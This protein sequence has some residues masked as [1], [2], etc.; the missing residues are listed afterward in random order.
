MPVLSD[1]EIYQLAFGAF[2][3]LG[4]DTAIIFGAICLAESGGDTQAILDNVAGGWQ[5]FGSPYQWD[6]G[7]AQINSIHGFDAQLLLDDPAYNVS[8]ARAIYN[9]QGFQAWSVFKGGQFRAF[10][11][12]M[13]SAAT[14]S[15]PS[16]P[17]PEP[18]PFSRDDLIPLYFQLYGYEQRVLID[19]DGFE[20]DGRRRYLLILP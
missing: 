16:L 18:P 14:A 19:P 8:C 11:Q 5:P 20:P 1:V 17:N 2:G 13:Q 9:R 7:L 4:Q 6:R 15:A 3:D 10:L 12:R